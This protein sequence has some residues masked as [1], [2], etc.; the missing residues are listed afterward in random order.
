MSIFTLGASLQMIDRTYGRLAQDAENQDRELLNAY[1]AAT[2]SAS[3]HVVGTEFKED[4]A[5]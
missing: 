2:R 5:L 4:A 3:G 1:D